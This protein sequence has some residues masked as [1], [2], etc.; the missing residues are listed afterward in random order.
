LRLRVVGVTRDSWCLLGAWVLIVGALVVWTVA[1][2][3]AVL[4]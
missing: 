2:G 3:K 4:G 1:V